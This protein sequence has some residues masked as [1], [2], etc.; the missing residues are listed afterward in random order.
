MKVLVSMAI[1]LA[2]PEPKVKDPGSPLIRST[3]SGRWSDPATW[4]GGKVPAAGRGCRSARGIVVTFDTKTEA[5]IRSI[6]VAGT[7]RFDP[8]R[9]TRLDVGL[10]KIQA[11]DDARE[12]GFDCESHAM[13]PDPHKERP[14]LEVGMPD[15][16]D[17]PRPYRRHPVD[18]R[19]RARPGGMP[20]DRLLWRALGRARQPALPDLGQ[21]RRHG[22]GKA[23]P[24]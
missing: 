18:G 2:A 19:A 21:D 12:S 9:D 16:P 15:R 20:R 24:S 7:L 22:P 4:E 6:H 5:A 23:R 10:I 13:A 3:A 8:D 1:L 14:A 11:G 17:Q